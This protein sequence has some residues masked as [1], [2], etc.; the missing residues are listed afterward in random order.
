MHDVFSEDAVVETSLALCGEAD[1]AILESKEGIVLTN[2]DV[3]A[4]E[5]GCATLTEDDLS[6]KGLLTVVE[7]DPKVFGIGIS[8]VFC[9]TRGFLC[10][11]SSGE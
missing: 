7:L 10:C 6:G 5:A 11:H 4:W 8:T 1:N 2:T 3:L 9:C